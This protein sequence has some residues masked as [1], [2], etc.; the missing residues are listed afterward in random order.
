MYAHDEVMAASLDYF[1]GNDLA[2]NVFVSKYALRNK[3]DELV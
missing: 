1:G 2:A 3:A